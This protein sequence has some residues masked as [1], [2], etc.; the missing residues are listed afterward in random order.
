MN[1]RHFLATAAGAVAATALAQETAPKPDAAPKSEAPAKPKR[2][3]KKAVNLGMVKAPGASVLDKFKMIQDAGFE[4]V[5][6]NRPDAIPL[7]EIQAAMSTTG[8]PIANVICSTHWGKPITH[9]DPAVRAQGIRGVKLGLEETG[10]LGCDRMLLVPGVVNKEV[11]Y[12]DAYPRSQAGIRECIPT[13]EKAKV[14][15]AIENVW[16]HFLLS[17]LEAARFVDEINSP[18]VGWHFD[19][20]N[21]V[22]YGW[23]EQ[24]VQA[25][26]KRILTLHL[27]EFSLKKQDTEGPRK[28]FQVELGEG[29]VNWAAVMKRLDEIPFAGWGVLEVP[30]GDAERLKFLSE[31]TDKLFAA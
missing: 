8:L 6:L 24:W 16:N 14:K 25:L 7:E 2:P 1:R 21:V 19:I 31:R 20:G 23:P 9:Q 10:V 15:I 13:A 4:G 12:V 3:L 17:P 22:T 5:E 27:K 28:G 29:D 18:W 30:G 11:S 26:G